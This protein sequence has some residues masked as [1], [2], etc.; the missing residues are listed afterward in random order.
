LLEQA[1]VD[2]A[3]DRLTRPSGANAYA[4]YRQVLELAPDHPVAREGLRRL[5]HRYL[6]LAAGALE[7]GRRD[8]AQAYLEQAERFVPDVPELGELRER[9]AAARPRVEPRPEPPAEPEVVPQCLQACEAAFAGCREAA[10]A[11]GGVDACMAQRRAQCGV[12]L[13]ACRSDA[14][15]LFLWGQVGTDS[16]CAGEHHQCIERAAAECE[17]IGQTGLQACEA[18][19]EQCRR[20]CLGE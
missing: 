5:G 4:R 8:Q 12:E 19:A 18:E 3:A 9:V 11:A 7:R 16:A 17:T 13:D 15:K 2:F 1:E 20:R 10:H 6:D 14:Q